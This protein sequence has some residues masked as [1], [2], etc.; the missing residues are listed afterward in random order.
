VCILQDFGDIV[1]QFFV[2]AY[3]NN[4]LKLIM[5]FQWAVEYCY[6]AQFVAVFDD[7]YF[8]NVKNV[9]SMLKTIKPTEFSSTIVGYVWNNAMPFR[10]K[11]SRWYISLDEYP[12]R[13]FPPYVSSGAFFMAMMAVERLYI[14]MQYTKTMRFDDVFFGIVALKLKMRLS[15]NQNI[16]FYNLP[17]DIFRYRKVIASD[18]FDDQEFLY[19]TWRQQNELDVNKA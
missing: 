19:K 1:Q 4:T 8:I 2:D 11:G 17:Y 16:Y 9:I 14:G 12:Y 5:G 18:G 6:N 10:V 15:H 7:S 3:F 13:Y